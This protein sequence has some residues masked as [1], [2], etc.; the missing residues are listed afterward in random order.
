MQWFKSQIRVRTPR[1]GLHD[2]TALVST[3][4]E[5]L[6]VREGMVF[7][8]L[9][10]TSAGLCISEN[11]DPTAKRDLEAF[12]DRMAPDGETWHEHTLEGKDDSAS[13]MRSLLTGVNLS[14]PVENGRMLL[15]TWQ[16]IYLCEHRAH[17][18]E[19][20]LLLR[21]LAV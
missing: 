1:R 11:Y 10:H 2:V 20:T 17:P 12:L 21:A 7:L 8:Y 19:R 5:R 3:E 18:H 9:Q 13:H 4:L 15:G 6:G 14:I 16:G